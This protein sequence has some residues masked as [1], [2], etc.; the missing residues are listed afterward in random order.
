[1]FRKIMAALFAAIMLAFVFASCAGNESPYTPGSTNPAEPTGSGEDKYKYVDANGD[2]QWKIQVEPFDWGGREFKVLVRSDNA[3]GLYKDVDFTFDE[4][5][6]GEPINDA[7]YR[8]TIEIENMFNIT[9]KPIG[10]KAPAYD[11]DHIKFIRASVMAGDKAYDITFNTPRSNGV[12]ARE[13]ILYNLFEFPNIDLSEPW[14]DKNFVDN[15]SIGGKIYQCGGDISLSFRYTVT[16]MFFNKQMLA[17]LGLESPY[18]LIKNNQWTFDKLSEMAKTVY[19]EM[20]EAGDL[21]VTS[22][23]GIAGYDGVLNQALAAAGVPFVTK[24]ENDIPQLA[25]Y[26]ERTVEVFEKLIETLYDKTLLYNWQSASVVGAGGVSGQRKFLNNQLLFYWNEMYNAVALRQMDTDFGIL[27][28]PK[29][30]SNQSRYY[31]SINNQQAC[32]LAI[33]KYSNQDEHPYI[34]AVVSALATLGKNYLTPAFYDIT[35][36]GKITR[37]EDSSDMLD[38]IFD[39]VMIDQ[40]RMYNIG[41]MSSAIN[42]MMQQNNR[43][44]ASWWASI[45]TVAQNDIDK[46]VADYE[47]N[48]D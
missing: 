43:N 35:L 37:D 14:W 18:T 44:I 47:N 45:E 5:I 15:S 21:S 28:P 36:K 39:N 13:G 33:P 9:I 16:S 6:D 12:M 27:P 10:A 17:D 25:F 2:E 26:S 11:D 23:I 34:G 22:V 40:G 4:Q 1:M 38:I 3:D 31:I 30:D 32:V 48:N 29:F 41:N 46:M 8:R 24:D 42:T 7:A 20:N 19:A